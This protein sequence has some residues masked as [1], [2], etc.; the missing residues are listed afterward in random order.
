MY[1]WRAVDHEGE[2]LDMLVQRRRDKRAALRLMRK[3]LK[4]QG[5]TPKLLTT[6]KLG[7]YGSAFR[8]LRLACPHEQGLRKNC[9]KLPSSG[10]TTRAQDATVQVSSIRPAL[11]QHPCRRPQHIQSSTTPRPRSTLRTFRAEAA[12]Q[13]QDAVAAA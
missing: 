10:A 13:W 3:L 1:L 8:H 2:V 11:P 7:S 9:G 6:D 5:F 4:K 12:A